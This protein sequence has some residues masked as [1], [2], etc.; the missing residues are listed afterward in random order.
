MD[1]KRVIILI[2]YSRVSCDALQSS[3]SLLSS[4]PTVTATATSPVIAC[5]DHEHD[6]CAGIHRSISEIVTMNKR[7]SV[8]PEDKAENQ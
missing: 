2:L 7:D 1:R 8:E 5:H 4:S 3:S 6:Q